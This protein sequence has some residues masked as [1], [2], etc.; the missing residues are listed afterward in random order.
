MAASLI[1]SLVKANGV[2]DPLPEEVGGAWVE[3]RALGR[4]VG[5]G[6]SYVLLGG[7]WGMG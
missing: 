2:T 3:L 6:L 1:K 4:L 7:W 5:H